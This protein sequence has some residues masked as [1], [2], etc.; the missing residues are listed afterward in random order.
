VRGQGRDGGE[1]REGGE[2]GE[3]RGEE[4]AG[5]DMRV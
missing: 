2:G 5:R 3:G 4:R 1:S